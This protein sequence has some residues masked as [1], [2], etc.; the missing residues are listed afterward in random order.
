[1]KKF[2][3]SST[4]REDLEK[5]LEDKDRLMGLAVQVGDMRPGFVERLKS[6]DQRIS[7]TQGLYTLALLESLN[8]E[9]SRLTRLTIALIA[10]TIILAALALPSFILLLRSLG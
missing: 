4:T 3:Y 5:L 7:E 10:L 6:L 1:M 9:S 2:K 8:R